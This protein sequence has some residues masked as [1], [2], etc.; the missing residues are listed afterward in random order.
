MSSSV[1]ASD[2]N[3]GAGNFQQILLVDR[4]EIA[5]Q[6]RLDG[7]GLLF[8]IM[9]GDGDG[10]L[11]Q[12]GQPRDRPAFFERRPARESAASTRTSSRAAS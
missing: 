2:A 10:H 12:G 7:R 9:P 8:C 11:A 3:D 4:A 5:R 6:R 1:M